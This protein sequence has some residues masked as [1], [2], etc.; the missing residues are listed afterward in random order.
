[1]SWYLL[2]Y[3]G[4]F[5][6]ASCVRCGYKV[7]GKEIEKEIFTQ[8]VPQCPK[9]RGQEDGIMKPDIVFF[10][11]NLPSEFHDKFKQD[12]D[13]V[14]LLIVM[15]SSLKVAPVANVKGRRR[16]TRSY[17]CA[18]TSNL[19]QHGIIATHGAIRYSL[20]WL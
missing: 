17:S 20:D 19:D 13:K 16:L 10:G 9:C 12:K 2:I 3:E 15:G 4:S 8:T 18:R 7:P 6:T 14:D 5:A 11:E 1:M